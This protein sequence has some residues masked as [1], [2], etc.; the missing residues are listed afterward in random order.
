M[1]SATKTN[2]SNT[3]FV[4]S[5]SNSSGARNRMQNVNTDEHSQNTNKMN[6]K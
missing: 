4:P 5:G 2:N 3:I 6:V 1:I